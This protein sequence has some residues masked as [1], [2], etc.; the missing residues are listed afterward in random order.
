MD[1][2]YLSDMPTVL[3]SLMY[4][5][6][7]RAK[8]ANEGLRVDL[9]GLIKKEIISK[10]CGW[11]KRKIL[12]RLRSGAYQ[13]NPYFFGKGDWKDIDNIRV[14]WHYDEINGRTGKLT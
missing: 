10:E 2:L 9:S 14:N 3:N 13:F 6:L 11:M 12:K 8:Y 7:K 4:S 1:M 5:L